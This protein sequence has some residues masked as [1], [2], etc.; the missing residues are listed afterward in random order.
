MRP[1]WLR[2]ASAHAGQGSSICSVKF[3]RVFV[4]DVSG[5]RDYIC[6]RGLFKGWTKTMTVMTSVWRHDGGG[7]TKRR[8]DANRYG[9]MVSP[10]MHST[11]VAATTNNCF[12]T[13]LAKGM[14][15]ACLSGRWLDSPL[16]KRRRDDYLQV[17][18]NGDIYMFGNIGVLGQ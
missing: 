14:W 13:R 8:S 3:G 16:I 2:A 9:D 6:V 7:G 15:C 1:Y 4:K 5:R 18:S 12:N 10:R 17:Y 11:R